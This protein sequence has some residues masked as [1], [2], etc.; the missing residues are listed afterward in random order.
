MSNIGGYIASDRHGDQQGCG[1]GTAIGAALALASEQQSLR[2]GATGIP[3]A[4][5]MYVNRV[6]TASLSAKSA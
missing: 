2:L 4:H 3:K 1:E 5:F 6:R